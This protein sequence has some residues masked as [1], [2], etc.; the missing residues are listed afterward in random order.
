MQSGEV[1]GMGFILLILEVRQIAI[2]A[3]TETRIPHAISTQ[4]LSVFL[5]IVFTIWALCST[6]SSSPREHS[7]RTETG[8]PNYRQVS[9]LFM[10][11]TG[12]MVLFFHAPLIRGWASIITLSFMA[13]NVNFFT[14]MGLK[15][16]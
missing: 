7:N 15:S 13:A 1:V 11:A 12:V 8:R 14:L 4:V 16:P 3:I 6:S 2:P 10:V 5:F 9:F